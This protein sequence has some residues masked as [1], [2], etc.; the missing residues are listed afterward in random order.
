MNLREDGTFEIAG[1]P[2]EVS[3]F[4]IGPDSTAQLNWAQT[5]D[6]KGTWATGWDSG[7]NQPYVV[8]DILKVGTN[9]QFYADNEKDAGELYSHFGDPDSGIWFYFSKS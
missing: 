8:M 2:V 3:Q 1:I 6:P 4:N 7:S 9:I 5:R